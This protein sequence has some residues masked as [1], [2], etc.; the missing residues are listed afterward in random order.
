M[1]SPDLTVSVYDIVILSTV[2]N[3]PLP[4]NLRDSLYPPEEGSDTHDTS[5]EYSSDSE[6]LI[7]VNKPGS[8][9]RYVHKLIIV[10]H[11]VHL[12]A[13]GAS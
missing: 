4:I 8:L 9:A 13:S 6:P 3:A 12:L 5:S 1:G 2:I 11:I 10:G 7:N